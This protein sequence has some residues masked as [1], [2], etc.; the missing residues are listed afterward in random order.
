MGLLV[1][2]L[3]D[4]S[5]QQSRTRKLADGALDLT[6]KLLVLARLPVLKPVRSRILALLRDADLL[7]DPLSLP[8]HSK[9]NGDD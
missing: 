5:A 9:G 1:L 7:P 2:F 3:Y 8:I 6:M 4:D